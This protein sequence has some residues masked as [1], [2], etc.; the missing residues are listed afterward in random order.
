MS[1]DNAAYSLDNPT[2]GYL[3]TETGCDARDVT[4]NV[5]VNYYGSMVNKTT[6]KRF[7]GFRNIYNG[8]VLD[9]HITENDTIIYYIVGHGDTGC[10]Y[11]KDGYIF[12]DDLIEG[13]EKLLFTHHYLHIYFI[14][15]TCKAGS[16]FS[17]D[18]F[19][20]FVYLQ[21]FNQSFEHDINVFSATNATENS[22]AMYCDNNDILNYFVS[23]KCLTD[24]FSKHWMDF[25]QFGSG[26]ET[27]REMFNSVKALTNSPVTAYGRWEEAA[28]NRTITDVFNIGDYNPFIDIWDPMYWNCLNSTTSSPI[29]DP[30][31]TPSNPE[32]RRL[33]DSSLNKQTAFDLNKERQVALQTFVDSHPEWKNSQVKKD[34]IRL[35]NLELRSK[36][37]TGSLKQQ[38]MQLYNEEKKMIHDID[39]W[40]ASFKKKYVNITF[41]PTDV[42]EWKCFHRIVEK[43][44]KKYGHS[45]YGMRRFF[46]LATLCNHDKNAYKYF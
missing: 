30:S 7:I 4:F 39:A 5:T 20:Q 42:R 24:V 34:L 41:G 32:V 10:L 2:H 1:P 40:E 18:S 46:Y 26:N 37:F 29:Q 19:S 3:F 44:D 22:Y 9:I 14:I 45:V 27:I 6:F 35:K 43:F 25:I 16:L 17:H 15:D 13:M 28:W 12:Y 8:S 23:D 36:A 38:F 11:M 31:I 21:R 33:K